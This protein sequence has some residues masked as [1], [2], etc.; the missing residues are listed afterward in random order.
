MPCVQ[1]SAVPELVLIIRSLVLQ[2][3]Q[4]RWSCAVQL[5]RSSNMY[6]Q[7][8]NDVIVQHSDNKAAFR[9][10]SRESDGQVSLGSC[11]WSNVQPPLHVNKTHVMLMFCSGPHRSS[12]CCEASNPDI[13]NIKRYVV[14]S[15]EAARR[16]G[17]SNRNPN[18]CVKALNRL[19][20]S[21]VV[22]AP[23]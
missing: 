12:A 17:S 2:S 10:P 14:Q 5:S 15:T 6:Q 1:I 8:S 11:R 19:H 21:T 18:H 13:S 23:S 16:L 4:W 7:R 22:I 9:C 3:C 20:D